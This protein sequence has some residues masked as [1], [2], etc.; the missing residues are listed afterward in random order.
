MKTILSIGGATMLLLIGG[1]WWSQSL[2][3]S[4]PDSI[5]RSGVH[6]HPTLAIYVKGVPQEIPANIGVGPQY[7]GAPGYDPQMQMMAV[8]THDDMP[9]IHLEFAGGPVRKEDVTLGQ[10]FKIWGKD[11]R[12]FGSTMY[13]TVNGEENTD[14]ENYVMRDKDKIELRYE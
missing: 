5:S 3:T 7:A 2:Q 1:V 11:M 13:M 4:D 14:Y 8:H 10:F 9:A 6:W 12:S